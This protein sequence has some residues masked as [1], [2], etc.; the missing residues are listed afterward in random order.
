MWVTKLLIS[1][2]KFRIFCPR[3]SKFGPKMAF[4]FI[5]GQ[6]LPAHL[7]GGCGARAVSRKTPNYS[8]YTFYTQGLSFSG[9]K[10]RSVNSGNSLQRGATSMS[11]GIFDKILGSQASSILEKE[12][13]TPMAVARKSSHKVVRHPTGDLQQQK[14]YRH[15]NEV[16]HILHILKID[17]NRTSKSQVIVTSFPPNFLSAMELPLLGGGQQCEKVK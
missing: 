3:K 2:V 5:F 7:V 4:L 10:I 9:S 14:R 16:S 17:R 13:H 8:I 1:P 15:P 12:R 6:A 11:D